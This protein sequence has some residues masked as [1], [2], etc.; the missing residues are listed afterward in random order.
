MR[1]CIIKHL[2]IQLSHHNRSSSIFLRH[3]DFKPPTLMRCAASTF[4]YPYF[5]LSTGTGTAKSM[6]R[7]H[8]QAKSFRLAALLGW[9]TCRWHTYYIFVC[10]Y[11]WM[12]TY[13]FFIDS[14]WFCR[15][16]R[17]NRFIIHSMWFFFRFF[18]NIFYFLFWLWCWFNISIFTFWSR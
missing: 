12:Y 18:M 16:N 17:S 1:V 15:F 6:C 11:G 2:A 10:M 9:G 4:S 3:L 14:M 7:W 5:F 13:R 8:Q